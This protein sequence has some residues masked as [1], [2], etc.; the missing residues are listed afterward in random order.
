MLSAF[1]SVTNTYHFLIRYIKTSCLYIVDVRTQFGNEKNIPETL[2]FLSRFIICSCWANHKPHHHWLT[3]LRGVMGQNLFGVQ[4][5]LPSN[6]PIFWTSQ[7][8]RWKNVMQLYVISERIGPSIMMGPTMI[9]RPN[10]I[11][12]SIYSS[13]RRWKTLLCPRSKLVFANMWSIT[14]YGLFGIG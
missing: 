10:C 7:T 6:N 1:V 11:N 12:I 3:I 8:N 2:C 9:E 13:S 14:P 5:N 4:F